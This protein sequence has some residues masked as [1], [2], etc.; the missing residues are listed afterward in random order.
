[1][2]KAHVLSVIYTKQAIT[3]SISIK[4]YLAKKFS[5]KEIEKFY[6][7][8]TA[9]EKVVAVFPE[10]YSA[11]KNKQIRRAVLSKQLS[12]FYIVLKENISVVAVLDNRMDDSKWP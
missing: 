11:I 9:F 10:L 8:L 3:D 1:M 6:S 12:V 7:M 4:N 2:D 5:Q